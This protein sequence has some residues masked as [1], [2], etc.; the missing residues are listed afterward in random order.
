MQSAHGAHSASS[1]LLDIEWERIILDEAHCI[2]NT[3]TIVSAACC[4]LKAKKRWCVTGT[5]LQ[6]SLTDVYGLL[7]FL[8][9]EPWCETSF[10]KTT[11][12]D[13]LNK[14]K[15]GTIDEK[16]RPILEDQVK[17]VHNRVKRLLA[18]I[19]LRRTIDTKKADG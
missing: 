5:P 1:K 9:H 4:S 2:K 8:K 16:N 14:A 10:W 13:P 6:N 11:I 18:P 15:S 3:Q 19:L 12:S 17:D 7:K